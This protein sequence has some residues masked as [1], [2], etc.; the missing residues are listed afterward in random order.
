MLNEAVTGAREDTGLAIRT[1][2][3]LTWC[4]QAA[5]IHEHKPQQFA[6][7]HAAFNHHQLHISDPRFEL[8]ACIVHSAGL[9]QLQ[10]MRGGVRLPACMHVRVCRVTHL[11]AVITASAAVAE[12]IGEPS[13][14]IAQ[15]LD[16]DNDCRGGEG[17][18]NGLHAV[19]VYLSVRLLQH[20]AVTASQAP[21]PVAQDIV[22]IQYMLLFARNGALNG[23]MLQWRHLETQAV[24]CLVP[25]TA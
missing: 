17:P 1:R 25:V 14:G 2:L 13:G 3:M 6:R 20:V 16:I 8:R 9:R 10:A 22:E 12:A 18:G 24:R 11:E 23:C 19:P 21:T 15:H 5:G 7:C 4:C